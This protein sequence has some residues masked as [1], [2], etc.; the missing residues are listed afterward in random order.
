MNQIIISLKKYEF[1]AN[2]EF[3]HPK[4]NECSGK[5]KTENTTGNSTMKD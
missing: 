2:V 1:M 4:M 3:L 5:P